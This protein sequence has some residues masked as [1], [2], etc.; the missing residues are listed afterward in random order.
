[1]R[2]VPLLNPSTTAQAVLLERQRKQRRLDG[3]SEAAPSS[4]VRVTVFRFGQH[5][6]TGVGAGTLA[7]IDPNDQRVLHQLVSLTFGDAVDLE[8]LEPSRVQLFLWPSGELLESDLGEQH[9]LC[10][11]SEWMR[12][13][14]CPSR[15][16]RNGQ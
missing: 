9:P 12:L 15:R 13:V 8:R 5:L 2:H 3:L 4:K 6:K 14:V 7:R 11:L 1:M 10:R 16:S